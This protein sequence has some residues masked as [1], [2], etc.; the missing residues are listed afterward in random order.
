MGVGDRRFGR[1]WGMP[2]ATSSSIFGSLAPA[3]GSRW[4][5]EVGAR[6]GG[7]RFGR[8]M[9]LV[10]NRPKFD[11]RGRGGVKPTEMGVIHSFSEFYG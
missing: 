9:G 7:G 10:E 11:K 1:A 2:S 6:V 4:G 5:R 8:K 3:G